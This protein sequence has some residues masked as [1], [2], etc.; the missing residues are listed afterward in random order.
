[1]I[2]KLEVSGR[3]EIMQFADDL[4]FKAWD[5]FREVMIVIEQVVS[6]EI[7]VAVTRYVEPGLYSKTRGKP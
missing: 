7:S 1:M 3:R 6:N 4:H 5:V 2:L